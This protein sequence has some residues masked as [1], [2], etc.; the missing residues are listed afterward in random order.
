MSLPMHLAHLRSHSEPWRLPGFLAALAHAQLNESPFFYVLTTWAAF[1][2]PDVDPVVLASFANRLVSTGYD[3]ATPSD[4]VYTTALASPALQGTFPFATFTGMVEAVHVLL[5]AAARELNAHGMGKNVPLTRTHMLAALAGL[6][7]DQPL[8]GLL[9]AFWAF[10]GQIVTTAPRV[11]ALQPSGASMAFAAVISSGN[12]AVY[13]LEVLHD[14]HLP[15]A[16]DYD[17]ASADTDEANAWWIALIVV[18]IV[19]VVLLLAVVLWRRRSRKAA[20]SAGPLTEQQLAQA[21]SVHE[22]KLRVMRRIEP[23]DVEIGEAIGHGSFGQIYRG[24]VKLRYGSRTERD[25]MQ[26]S[27]HSGTHIDA[28]PIPQAALS[29]A[30]LY[31]RSADPSELSP[32]A[33]VPLLPSAASQV[34]TTVPVCIKAWQSLAELTEQSPAWIEQTVAQLVQECQVL[35]QFYD[36]EHFVNLQG[37]LMR[38]DKFLGAVYDYC[39][40]GNLAE[41]LATHMVPLWTKLSMACDVAMGM[42]VLEKY[43]ATHLDLSAR[44]VLVTAERRCKLMHIGEQRV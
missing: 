41:H 9:N 42:E 40:G 6:N 32:N 2:L 39:A 19:A 1:A 8:P 27:R 23:Q 7:S 21:L 24:E 29:S 37:L 20:L 38:E 11:S 31:T 28:A 16:A 43:G 12:V 30:D 34:V 17:S 14:V 22:H 3:R 15:T 26:Y 36:V 13:R 44:H 5:G 25:V 33:E 18:G 4:D 10:H 35:A